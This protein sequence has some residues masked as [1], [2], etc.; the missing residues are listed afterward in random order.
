M[1]WQQRRAIVRAN[2][3]AQFF[4]LRWRRWRLLLKELHYFLILRLGLALAI[5]GLLLPL[6]GRLLLLHRGLLILLLLL[7]GFLLLSH[8]F[9]LLLLL[10]PHGC[11]LP[12]HGCLLIVDLLLECVLAT[13]V[14]SD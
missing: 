8:G 9:L 5:H 13:K 11:R 3:K 7:H 14:L 12:P 2:G 6:Y 1:R 10:P 4:A